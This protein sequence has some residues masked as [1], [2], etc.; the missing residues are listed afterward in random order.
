L[1]LPQQVADDMPWAIALPTDAAVQRLYGKM[2]G[3]MF[4]EQSLPM[5]LLLLPFLPVVHSV[6]RNVT[7]AMCGAQV[8]RS[9]VDRHDEWSPEVR[10]EHLQIYRLRQVR[11]ALGPL[12]P[13]LL[14]D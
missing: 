11:A 9:L 12:A 5:R 2:A 14:K 1:H 6:S 4:E 8:F 13:V 3:V 7:Q 10:A